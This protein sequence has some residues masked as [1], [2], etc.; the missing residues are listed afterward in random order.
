VT[1]ESGASRR[2]IAAAGIGTAAPRPVAGRLMKAAAAKQ[3]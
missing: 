1:Q 3:G 2:S